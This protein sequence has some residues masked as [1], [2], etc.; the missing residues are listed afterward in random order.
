MSI[1]NSNAS[2]LSVKQTVN[3]FERQGWNIGV[4]VIENS[5]NNVYSI[6]GDERFSTNSTVKA[7][8]CAIV[9]SE[10][11]KNAVSL[12]DA[13]M[14]NEQDVVNHSPVMKEFIGK[15]VTLADA[16]KATMTYSDNTAANFAIKKSGGP[17]GITSFLRSMGDDITRADRYEPDLNTNPEGDLRDTSTANAMAANFNK[18][19]LGNILSTQSKEQLKD[20]MMGNKVADNMLRLVLPTGWEIADRTGANSYGARG[21]ISMVW[22]ES[23]QPLIISIYIKKENTAI[24][25]REKVISE[26]GRVIFTEYTNGTLF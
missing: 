20:W 5:S 6:N 13:M 14:I 3:E 18:L 21:I 16:C 11:D 15:K 17:E 24:E 22:S 8:A 4:S 7:L 12:N 23:Q 19:L 25:E 9:L 10:V 1:S 2:P 26:I